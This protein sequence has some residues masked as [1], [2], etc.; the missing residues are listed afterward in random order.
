MT[1]VQ[2][3]ALPISLL[4][5]TRCVVPVANTDTN[6]YYVSLQPICSG[7]T[8]AKFVNPCLSFKVTCSSIKIGGSTFT[9]ATQTTASSTPPTNP[10]ILPVN[11]RALVGVCG[12]N[13]Y[14]GIN[15]V[16]NGSCG[17]ANFA[18][19]FPELENISKVLN[20]TG[21]EYVEV[22]FSKYCDWNDITTEKV[23]ELKEL[24]DKYNLKAISSQ[25][26]FYNVDCKSIV[27]ESEK[28]INH[29]QKLI[30]YS[31]ILGIKVLVFGSPALRKVGG[32]TFSNLHE[33]FN[34]IDALLDGTDI[35]FCIEPKIGRA[36]V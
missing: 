11:G 5:P 12:G 35:V 31:K 36:H 26:L 20:E 2:T 33:T 23:T 15:T 16:L 25:S 29:V 34:K 10:I 27:T 19:D 1:G 21:I 22:V 24:L 30:E 32:Y 28:F 4:K 8:T 6:S 3:C 7:K 14:S 9:R 13:Y 18:W 17:T